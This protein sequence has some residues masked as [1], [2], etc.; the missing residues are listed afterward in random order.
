MSYTGCRMEGTA[1]RGK[2]GIA[3]RKALGELDPA[4][5]ARARKR[6]SPTAL[7]LVTQRFVASDWYGVE[8]IEEVITVLAD[9]LGWEQERMA[10]TFGQ[11]VGFTG[12]GPVGR[13]MVSVFGTPERFEKY[14]PTTWR[15]LYDSGTMHARF[16]PI[17]GVLSVR[18]YGWKGHS[19][20]HCFAPLGAVEALASH[21]RRPRLLSAERVECVAEGA[22]R[23]SY[24]L[25]FER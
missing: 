5:V 15:Q 23:C 9:E 4:A 25:T 16:D 24:E 7:A 13:A 21:V 12:A 2:L 11:K 10:R 8:G 3:V 14:L 19:R 1:F 22:K 17:D 6:L 18:V 20:L